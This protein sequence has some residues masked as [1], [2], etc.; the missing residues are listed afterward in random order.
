V[1]HSV[2]LVRTMLDLACDILR[3]RP[4]T[5]GAPQATWDETYLP[6]RFGSFFSWPTAV[7]GADSIKRGIYLVVCF[8]D[9][10]LRTDDLTTSESCNEAVRNLPRSNPE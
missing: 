3:L 9:P 6:K 4:K 5:F 10:L 8:V 2:S 7:C 1:F